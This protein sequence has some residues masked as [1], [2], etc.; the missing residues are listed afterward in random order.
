MRVRGTNRKGG[1]NRLPSNTGYEIL[2][3]LTRAASLSGPDLTREYFDEYGSEIPVGTL[4]PLLSRM[5]ASGWVKR[6][7]DKDT[8]D[9]RVRYFKITA[10]G[11]WSAMKAWEEHKRL[12]GH[13]PAE[14]SVRPD[15]GFEP[16]P[17]AGGG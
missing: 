16:V 2:V 3:L 11:R 13:K 5:E 14:G 9:G 6:C 4:H 15:P 8:E 17:K 1:G 7:G 12:A 10:T